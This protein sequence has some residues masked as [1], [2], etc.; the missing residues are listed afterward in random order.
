MGNT[1]KIAKRLAEGV[2]DK[3]VLEWLRGR[4][5]TN[6]LRDRDIYKWLK[7]LASFTQSRVKGLPKITKGQYNKD[8]GRA[9][10]KKGGA[11]KKHK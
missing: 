1:C 7:Y 8:Y 4:G 2:G 10:N 3:I 6:Y 11:K 9:T 5:S